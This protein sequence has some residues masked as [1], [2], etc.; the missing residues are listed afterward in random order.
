MAFPVMSL[1]DP[2]NEA[3]GGI[4]PLGM[5]FVAEHLAEAML[6]GLTQRMARPRF[7]TLMSIGAVVTADLELRAADGTPPE[8]AFEWLV[9]QALAQVEDEIRRVPGI[10]KA[11]TVIGQALPMTAQR[12]LKGARIF[13]FNG[14]YKTLGVELGLFDDQFRLLLA[15]ERLV[16]AFEAATGLHG[17][18]SGTSDSEGKKLREKLHQL[19]VAALTTGEAYPPKGPV[20]EAL[21]GKLRPDRPTPPEAALL[22][23][24][25]ADPSGGTRGEVFTLVEDPQVLSLL[26]TTAERSVLRVLQPRASPQLRSTLVA[27][28][29]FEALARTVQDAFD[30]IRHLSTQ[31]RT[32]PISPANLS[33]GAPDLVAPLRAAL[34]A[35]PAA[36]VGYPG[37]ADLDGLMVHF[38]TV[39]TMDELF[40]A[41]ISRHEFIQRRK[42]P[43][44][45]RSWFE[46]MPDGSAVVRPLYRFEG[47]PD[48][49]DGGVHFYRLDTVGSFLK[50]LKAAA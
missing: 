49:G 19:I 8:I 22:R 42:L 18:L 23:Q 3:E 1:P 39:R 36:L 31:N 5:A 38:G 16:G 26:E 30:W 33:A 2:K 7:L 24:L 17:F 13:G 35:L 29:A 20:L 12:Y 25:I 46:R 41:V 10:T 48:R 47:P 50:D 37:A 43:N 44:G 28:E 21:T 11:R 9:V 34:D 4:D 6:P 45:K 32:Q 14:V 27:I 15:G 40:H